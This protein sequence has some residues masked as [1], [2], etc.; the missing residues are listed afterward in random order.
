MNKKQYGLILFLSVLVLVISACGNSSTT[1]SKEV[2]NSTQQESQESKQEVSTSTATPVPE[3][4]NTLEPTYTP[5][6]TNTPEPTATSTPIPP[7]T[8]T[9]TPSPEEL[10]NYT[11]LRQ[12]EPH[13][14]P[15]SFGAEILLEDDLGEEELVSFVQHF[16]RDF[17]PVVILVFTSM[18]AHDQITN[19][20]SM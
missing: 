15:N 16:N 3:P 17:D 7:P 8:E 4:T 13:E 2:A 19:N 5:E 6:P 18:E 11:T 12:W 20:N 1:S 14:I 10:V 9:P